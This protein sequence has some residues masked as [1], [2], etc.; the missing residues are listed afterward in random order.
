MA[1]T[2]RTYRLS[3]ETVA[4]VRALAARY[5]S[6]QDAVVDRAVEALERARRDGDETEVWARAAEDPE[7]RRES[8]ELAASFDEPGRWPA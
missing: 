5:G 7:F 1:R 3:P 4:L 2:K 8:A 6:S